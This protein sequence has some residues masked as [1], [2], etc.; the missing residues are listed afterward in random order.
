MAS[1]RK[2]R[3]GA[4]KDT[5]GAQLAVVK[6]QAE[7]EFKVPGEGL[8]LQK[9]ALDRALDD[10]LVSIRDTTAEDADRATGHRSGTRSPNS[11]N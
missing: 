8:D 6:A 9:T 7:A 3:R 2:I 10:R 1:A 11:R 4:E 5:T